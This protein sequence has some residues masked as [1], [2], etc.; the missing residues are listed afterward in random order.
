M[1][2]RVL[3]RFIL[4]PPLR[5]HPLLLAWAIWDFVIGFTPRSHVNLTLAPIRKALHWNAYDDLI[6]SSFIRR[7]RPIKCNG[8]D[9]QTD[10]EIR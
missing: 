9:E 6:W 10:G 5:T 8:K 4:L 3:S 7:P 1:I 2:I